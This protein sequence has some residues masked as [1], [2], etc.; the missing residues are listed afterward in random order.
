MRKKNLFGRFTQVNKTLKRNHEGTG[1]GLSLVKSFVELHEGEIK[2]ESELGHGSEFTI[3]L[4]S[5]QIAEIN[6]EI[7]IKDNIIERVN[8]ELSDI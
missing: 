7:E 4:P 6:T 1:I 8:M 2:L 3:I 5:K